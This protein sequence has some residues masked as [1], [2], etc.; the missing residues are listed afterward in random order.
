MTGGTSSLGGSEEGLHAEEVS[1]AE[2]GAMTFPGSLPAQRESTAVARM[3][4][5]LK[6]L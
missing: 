3:A 4:G 2:S 6:A 1:V 5:L